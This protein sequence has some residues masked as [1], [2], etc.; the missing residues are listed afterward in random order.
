LLRFA[1][2]DEQVDSPSQS[3]GSRITHPTRGAIERAPAVRP[4]AR[5]R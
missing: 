2:N 1:R 5:D 4:R 3:P